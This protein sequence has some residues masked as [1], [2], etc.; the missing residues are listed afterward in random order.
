M[1]FRFSSDNKFGLKIEVLEM[2]CAYNPCISEH[3]HAHLLLVWSENS[4]SYFKPRRSK[5]L[6]KMT[7]KAIVVSRDQDFFNQD[8]IFE[9]FTT[10]KH[11]QNKNVSGLLRR[12]HRV[13]RKNQCLLDDVKTM[14][15]LQNETLK[16]LSQQTQ[17]L[18]NRFKFK[19]ET[20][21]FEN[22]FGKD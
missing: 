13:I 7:V 22:N 8:A 4:R 18:D 5:D 2:K 17:S 20:L 9:S 21:S 15:S 12:C 6:K 19:Q 10:S 16:I 1:A 14:V 3:L 11:Q